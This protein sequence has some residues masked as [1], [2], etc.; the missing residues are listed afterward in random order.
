MKLHGDD[1]RAIQQLYGKKEREIFDDTSSTTPDTLLPGG[2]LGDLCEDKGRIDAVFG[3]ADDSYYA[4][5]GQH[6]YKL[7]Q[8]GNVES[9]YPRFIE[10]DWVGLPNDIDAGKKMSPIYANAIKCIANKLCFQHSLGPTTDTPTSS[11]AINIGDLIGTWECPK[12][13]HGR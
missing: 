7:T 5:K 12:A 10:A 3:T 11:K 4:F 9:G 13:I 2:Q 6:Y 1:I 8:E